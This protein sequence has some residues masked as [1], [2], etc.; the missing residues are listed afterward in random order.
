MPNEQN[1]GQLKKNAA[2][3]EPPQREAKI[4]EF[5]CSSAHQDEKK[6]GLHSAMQKFHANQASSKKFATPEIR[7]QLNTLIPPL[8]SQLGWFIFSD[9]EQLQ[10]YLL[11]A[12]MEN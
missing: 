11:G 12:E 4:L 3:N 7:T 2:S 9:K 8:A 10:P 1:L 5:Q 6:R